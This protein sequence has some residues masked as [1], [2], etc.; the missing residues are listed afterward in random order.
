MT[1]RE[2]IAYFQIQLRIKKRFLRKKIF[3]AQNCDGPLGR[4]VNVEKKAKNRVK[5]DKKRYL[6]PKKGVMKILIVL[7]KLNVFSKNIFEKKFFSPKNLKK[8]CNFG[9]FWSKKWQRQKFLVE[10]FFWSESIQ[11]GP[12][13]ILKRKSRFRKFFPIMT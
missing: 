12:K 1:F 6:W 11:N 5:F 3:E 13:R 9:H 4:K 8:T 2:K 10:N 7:S